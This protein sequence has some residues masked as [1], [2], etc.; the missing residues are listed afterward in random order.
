MD[1]ANTNNKSLL[2]KNKKRKV[3]DE[4]RIF[5]GDW[6]EKFAFTEKENKPMC[7]ICNT[8]LAHNKSG[9]VKRHYEMKQIFLRNIH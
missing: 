5:H 9:N 4:K 8:E 6:T 7:L 1:K 3:D 2:N